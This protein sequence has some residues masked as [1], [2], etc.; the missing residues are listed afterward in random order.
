MVE[1]VAIIHQ[2][3]GSD[4]GVSFPDFPG[5]ITA[6]S[7]LAEAQ[8]LAIDALALHIRGL[9]ADGTA[10][11]V[12]SS[13]AAVMEDPA[14]RDG[15]AA[16][17]RAPRRLVNHIRVNISLPEDTLEEIDQFALTHGYTRSGLLVFAAKR[18]MEAA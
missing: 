18:M 3:S 5:C 8:S 14:N 6:G 11:P 2:E 15:L 9:L 4:F 10:V 12:P 7:T 1:Y 13:L 16:F 17:V